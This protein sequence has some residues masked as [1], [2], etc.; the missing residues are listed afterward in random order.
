VTK[1]NVVLMS[2]DK[3]PTLKINLPNGTSLIKFKASVTEYE[4][5]IS[6]P[7][8]F[9]ITVIGTCNANSWNGI[10]TP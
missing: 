5:L 2:P 7:G 4:K 10:V 1:D 6:S 3:S 8:C 9:I